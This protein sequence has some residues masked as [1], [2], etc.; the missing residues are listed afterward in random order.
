MAVLCFL[1]QVSHCQQKFECLHRNYLETLLFWYQFETRSFLATVH[2]A[3]C[4]AFSPNTLS[5][6]QF[7]QTI[8]CFT[9]RKNKAYATNYPLFCKKYQKNY[10]SSPFPF[11]KE[12]SQW[13]FNVNHVPKKGSVVN[14]NSPHCQMPITNSFQLS[15]VQYSWI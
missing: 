13:A 14:I 3:K 4:K 5:K 6:W 12:S 2:L 7:K 9:L 1:Q 10:Y 15:I 8:A 11:P